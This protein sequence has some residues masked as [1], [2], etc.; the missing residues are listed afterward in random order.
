MFQ[1]PHQSKE[2]KPA[3]FNLGYTSTRI[4]FMGT[5]DFAV[6]SL[7]ALLKAGFSIVGV[8]TAPDKPA[9]RGMKLQESAVKVYAR[10]KGLRVLQPERLKNPAFL[11]ELRE[12]GADFQ[13]VVAFRMLPELVWNMPAGGTINLHASLLPQYRGAAP[14]NWAIINGE[15]V[16]GLTTFK[17]VQEIDHGNILLQEQL[18]I[19]DTETAG[20]LHD[21]MKIAGGA[22]LVRTISGLLDGTVKEIPQLNVVAQGIQLK[23][24]PKI[25]SETCRIDWNRPVGE[26][27][28]LVRGLS[29]YPGAFTT[30][31]GKLLKIYSAEKIMGPATVAPGIL[32]TD[33]RSYFRFACADGYLAPAEV[34]LEGK[35]KML[36]GDF[37]RGYR[38]PGTMA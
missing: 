3:T 21:R 11:E 36:T 38:L 25:Q 17:L 28:N 24:A 22:L 10:G 9:G 4:V 18:Q 23:T 6:A 20:E 26:V 1:Y 31:G 2:N 27:F 35:K 16:T 7:D 34:Q 14:I 37:L 30:L 8:I 19:S 15:K 29:P 32:E 5:P 12:L 13:V 33:N